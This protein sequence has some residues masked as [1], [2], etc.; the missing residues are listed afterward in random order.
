MLDQTLNQ[1]Q[2]FI[3]TFTFHQS[4]TAPNQISAKKFFDQFQNSSAMANIICILIDFMN[5]KLNLV[6]LS[7]KLETPT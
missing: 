4:I 5:F 6:H 7:D 1:T 2:N 3:K